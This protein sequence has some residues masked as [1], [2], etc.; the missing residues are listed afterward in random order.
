MLK[1]IDAIFAFLLEL[2]ISRLDQ[3]T[4]RSKELSHYYSMARYNHM[5][6]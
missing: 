1:A 3:S 4:V 5:D 6:A 2:S